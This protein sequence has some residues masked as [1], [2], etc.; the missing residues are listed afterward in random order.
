MRRIRYINGYYASMFNELMNHDGSDDEKPIQMEDT[1]VVQDYSLANIEKDKERYVPI[2]VHSIQSLVEFIDTLDD[3][4]LVIE[5]KDVF[6]KRFNK[7]VNWFYNVHLRFESKKEIP[8]VIDG[9]EIDLLHFY[10]I[11]KYMGG[12][13]KV[14]TENARLGVVDKLGFPKCFENDE[15]LKTEKEVHERAVLD[16]GPKWKRRNVD[17]YRHYPFMCG[18]SNFSVGNNDSNDEPSIEEYE[19][20]ETKVAD[21]VISSDD[22]LVII[23]NEDAK[24][25]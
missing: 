22:D 10:L 9:Y 4:N 25:A 11:V 6:E 13:R 1:K 2:Q 7:M 24:D 18:P 5:H 15:D 8:P 21:L 12:L 19:D 17:A 14:T 20:E 16:G 23:L 3:E